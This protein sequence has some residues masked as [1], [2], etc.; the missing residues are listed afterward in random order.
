M[1]PWRGV[2]NMIS[3]SFSGIKMLWLLGGFAPQTPSH[4]IN[5]FIFHA[6]LFT[7][8][9]EKW[10]HEEICTSWDALRKIL[11]WQCTPSLDHAQIQTNAYRHMG[12][13]LTSYWYFVEQNEMPEWSQL[14]D[15]AFQQAHVTRDQWTYAL[16]RIMFA[17]KQHKFQCMYVSE[18]S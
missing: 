8:T 1:N 4:I 18:S 3:I 9:T 7:T 16:T 5:L 2:T 15:W 17:E 13:I 12:S 14:W 11:L 10:R 6:P